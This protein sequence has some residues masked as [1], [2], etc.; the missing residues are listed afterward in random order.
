VDPVIVIALVLLAI[1]VV[2]AVAVALVMRGRGAARGRTREE[3]RSS[4]ERSVGEA[5]LAGAL[6][7]LPLGIVVC[8]E[9]GEAVYENAV[10]RRLTAGRYAETIVESAVTALLHRAIAGEQVTDTLD[11][12]G[13]PRWNLVLTAHP[14]AGAGRRSGAVVV[15]EDATERR[16]L[17]AVRRDFVA[18]ISHELKT[19]VGALGILAET[20]ADEQDTEVVKR[21]ADRI[22]D[23][24]QRV[25]HIIDDLL[26][27]SRIEAEE[28]PSRDAVPVDRIVMEAV[29]RVRNSAAPRDIDVKVDEPLDDATIV[30][31]RRQLVSAVANLLDNAV[32]YSDSGSPV[33]VRTL[34]DGGWVE[35]EVEDHGIGI[36]SRDLDR[37]FERF[38]RVDRART[39]ATG[40]T[41]LGLAIV[42]HVANN[43]DGSVRVRSQE[44]EGS[45][46]T[47]VLPTDS[48]YEPTPSQSTI[49]E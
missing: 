3:R 28:R 11:I 19:P 41:G 48:R 2:I 4:A 31:D 35:I 39:R 14:L 9:R 23:E 22:E 15:I 18:N 5:R 44:G 17:E 43:H 38:Y 42:R 20:M 21:L 6:D 24:A 36:P 8:D 12:Y 40:G 37:I 7:G 34:V 33:E 13:P 10:A 32:K 29:D 47:L 25:G 30:G 26:E 46:F 1:A 45:T 27:L 16:R 49:E